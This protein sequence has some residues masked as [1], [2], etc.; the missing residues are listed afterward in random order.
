[1]KFGANTGTGI[2]VTSSNNITATTPA[3]V[4]GAVNVVV[5]N[6]NALTAT[7]FNGFTYVAPPPVPTAIVATSVARSGANLNFIW[8]G[9]TNITS[10]LLTTTNIGPNAVWSPAGTNVFGGNGWSTNSVAINPP[11]ARSDWL[12]DFL[13]S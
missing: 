12:S 4:A 10:V 13:R 2:F 8:K 6:T 5:S 1:V 9:G 7:N 3:G 11:D